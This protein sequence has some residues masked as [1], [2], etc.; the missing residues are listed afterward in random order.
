MTSLTASDVRTRPPAVAFA[1]L[2]VSS[3][4]LAG[5]LLISGGSGFEVEDVVD[6]VAMMA[7]PAVGGLLL[8]RGIAPRIGMIFALVGLMVGLGFL[9]GGYS[10][11]G[12][13]GQPLAMLIGETTFIVVMFVLLTFLLLH[14]PDGHLP[15][16]RWRPAV[17]AS[18]A[19]LVASVGT[20]L[21]APGPLDEDDASSPANPLGL[22]GA[23][24]VLD[25][26]E[27]VSLIGF[28]VLAFLSLASMLLRLRHARGRQRRQ[29]GI[30]SAG[31]AVMVGLFFLDSTLQSIFGDVYGVVAAIAAISAIPV[32]TAIALLDRAG[33]R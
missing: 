21:L 12:R 22:A 14:F 2:A 28:A 15:S 17:W 29:I 8:S 33:E 10:E 27:L 3:A 26:L 1:P 7:F 31:A 24:D 30:L 11:T 20:T 13:P 23:E 9:V 19:V 32:A 25:L 5:G 6:G 4:M 18:A 16:A